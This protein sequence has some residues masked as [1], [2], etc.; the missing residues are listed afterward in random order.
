MFTSRKINFHLLKFNPINPLH[1]TQKNSRK[2]RYNSAKVDLQQ[3]KNGNQKKKIKRHPTIIKNQNHNLP[4]ED[5]DCSWW[6]GH[7]IYIQFQ[8]HLCL[9]FSDNCKR[10]FS[11]VVVVVVWVPVS[12]APNGQLCNTYII[13]ADSDKY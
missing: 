7:T 4:A 11:A 6:L 12:L 10:Q 3:N 9:S 5:K 2:S 8:R 13:I 1:I